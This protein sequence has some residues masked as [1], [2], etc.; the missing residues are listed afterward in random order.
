MSSLLG[1]LWGFLQAAGSRAL[2]GLL[3]EVTDTPRRKGRPV[4]FGGTAQPRGRRLDMTK[5][6]C[7]EGWPVTT[8][9]V[10]S[11]VVPVLSYSSNCQIQ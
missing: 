2:F 6:A 3:G 10:T 9:G 4:E 5:V 11:G 8:A 1:A 7:D